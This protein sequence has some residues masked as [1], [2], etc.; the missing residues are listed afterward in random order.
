[1]LIENVFGESKRLNYEEFLKINKD[2]TSEMFL[3]I[4]TLLQNSLPSS[5]NFYRFKKNYEKY[6]QAP[7]K[8]GPEGEQTYSSIASPKIMSK[9]SPI[10][11]FVS[12]VGI[13]VAPES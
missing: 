9:L 3:S 13:N 7:E 4:M 12:N 2:V 8:N 11:Q 6:L 10:S 5:T 1:M